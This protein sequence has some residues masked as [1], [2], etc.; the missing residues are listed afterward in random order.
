LVATFAFVILH[1]FGDPIEIVLVD[2]AEQQV[3][4]HYK[5]AVVAPGDPGFS[6]S[7]NAQWPNCSPRRF[8]PR[9]SS[10]RPRSPSSDLPAI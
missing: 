5:V 6:L 7:T 9:A 3:I 10:D 1:A 8:R 4:D 2:Q